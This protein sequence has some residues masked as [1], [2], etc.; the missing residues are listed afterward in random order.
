MGCHTAADLAAAAP[1]AF[2]HRQGFVRVRDDGELRR[3][4][5]DERRV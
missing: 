2:A 4:A 1:V 3:A 5:A